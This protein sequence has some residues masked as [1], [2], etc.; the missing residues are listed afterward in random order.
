MKRFL[1]AHTLI[2]SVDDPAQLSGTAMI[3]AQNPANDLLVS[4]A[5][6]W[7]IAIKYGKGKL[8]LSLPVRPWIEKAVAALDLTIFPI[9]LD[10]AELLTTLPF[11]HRDPFDRILAA[12]AL[13]E[14]I[15]VVSCDA[16]FDAYGV[17]RIW[18]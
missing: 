18:N 11:H 8:P 4:I 15:P 14:A 12:Q 10:H 13:V 16:I 2:W 17:A 3:E 5:S 7:E 6:I 9:A 1:D